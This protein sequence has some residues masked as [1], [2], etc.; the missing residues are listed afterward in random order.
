MIALSDE[1]LLAW[2]EKTTTGWRELI[3]KQPEILNLPCNVRETK[4]V[5]ELL[6]HIVAVELRYAERLKGLPETSYE[7]VPCGTPRGQER[8]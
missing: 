6:Q 5:A 2:A 4:A 8:S 7:G 3:A 1:E